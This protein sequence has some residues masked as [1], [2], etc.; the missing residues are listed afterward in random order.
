MNFFALTPAHPT[1]YTSLLELANQL[2]RKQPLP[3]QPDLLDQV[4]WSSLLSRSLTRISRQRCGPGRD[5][6]LS[7]SQN[8]TSH[9]YLLLYSAQ[10]ITQPLDVT[11]SEVVRLLHVHVPPSSLIL[12]SILTTAKFGNQCLVVG[13]L[14]A[15]GISPSP[16]IPPPWHMGRASESTRFGTPHVTMNR[17]TPETYHTTQHTSNIGLHQPS[18]TES[19]SL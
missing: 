7:T 19:S 2:C 13:A 17:Q 18:T 10:S 16:S 5:P 12:P 6:M 11:V 14:S 9:L 3:T 15:S 1:N 4:L 8:P